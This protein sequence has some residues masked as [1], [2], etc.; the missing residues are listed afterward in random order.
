M[1]PQSLK[2]HAMNSKVSVLELRHPMGLWRSGR[3]STPL[4]QDQTLP[5]GYKV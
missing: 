1:N 3:K 5:C 4:V 2:S